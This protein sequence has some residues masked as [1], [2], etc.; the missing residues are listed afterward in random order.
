MSAGR[1]EGQKRRL[2][3]RVRQ[4]RRRDVAAD[5]V[6]RDER[7]VQGKGKRLAEVRADEQ[8]TDKARRTGRRDRVHVV[9]IHAGVRKRLLGH[10]HDRLHMAARGNLGHDAA[11]ERVGRDLRVH[12]VRQ[13]FPSVLD[14]GGRRFIAGGLDSK[15][16]QGFHSNL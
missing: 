4:K 15:Y 8:R 7:L 16:S 3:L 6:H 13:H 14:D 9:L 11:V 2:Q 12:D 1:D 5:V 10:A